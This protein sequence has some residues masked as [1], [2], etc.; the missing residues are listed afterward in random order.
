MQRKHKQKVPTRTIL[1]YTQNLIRLI[2]TLFFPATSP[3]HSSQ[4]VSPRMTI[5]SVRTA[6]FFYGGRKYNV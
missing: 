2:R 6:P 4:V 3:L 5:V 1:L